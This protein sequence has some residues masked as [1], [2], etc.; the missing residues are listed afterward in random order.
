VIHA[1]KWI[2]LDHVGPPE[3]KAILPS[4]FIPLAEA[5]GYE[6]KVKNHSRPIYG[7]VWVKIKRAL[8][9]KSG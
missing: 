6:F 4:E 5:N 8:A 7:T 9:K 1:R 3:A 2:T